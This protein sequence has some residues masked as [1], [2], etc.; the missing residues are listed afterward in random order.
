[1]A[2]SGGPCLII[3]SSLLCS[4]PSCKSQS[5]NPVVSV[6]HSSPWRSPP[7]SLTPI[8]SAPSMQRPCHRKE[9]L[10]AKNEKKKKA[11]R[12]APRLLS[13]PVLQYFLVFFLNSLF[14]LHFPKLFFPT[15]AFAIFHPSLLQIKPWNCI[16]ASVF[17]LIIDLNWGSVWEIFRIWMSLSITTLLGH[18]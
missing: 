17:P 13:T 18:W 16:S 2:S 10:E 7:A 4:L 1:M 15:F 11:S 5:T 14:F 6:F 8:L 9:D 3:F 12:N